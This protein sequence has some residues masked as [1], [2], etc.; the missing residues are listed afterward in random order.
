MP[1]VIPPSP[2]WRRF[3]ATADRD[4]VVAR[5]QEQNRFLNLGSQIPHV[6][7]LRQPCAV[8]SPHPSEDGVVADLGT[9]TTDVERDIDFLPHFYHSSLKRP[10]IPRKTVVRLEIATQIGIVKPSTVLRAMC[11]GENFDWGARGRG[12]KSRR[13]D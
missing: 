9:A 3:A 4:R 7:G 2:A 12:F 1:L 13:P 6:H 11:R 5:R 8:T 10:E